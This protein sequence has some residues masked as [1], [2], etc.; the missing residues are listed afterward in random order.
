MTLQS[1]DLLFVSNQPQGIVNPSFPHSKCTVQKQRDTQLVCCRVS[2]I[3]CFAQTLLLPLSSI[4]SRSVKLT[5]TF[6]D[7]EQKTNY[8]H[9]QK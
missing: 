2:Q 1:S 7:K 6:E 3:F 4:S 5:D 9:L 8:L